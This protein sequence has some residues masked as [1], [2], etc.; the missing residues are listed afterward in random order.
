MPRMDFES[1]SPA[2]CLGC[3]DYLHAAVGYEHSLLIR[4]PSLSP[5]K[6]NYSVLSTSSDTSRHVEDTVN[7]EGRGQLHGLGTQAERKGGGVQF[8]GRKPQ[9]A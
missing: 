2:T 3:K 9:A 7:T 1:S 4:H 6:E 8:H 5:K